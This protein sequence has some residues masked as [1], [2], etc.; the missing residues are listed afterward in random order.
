MPVLYEPELR[1]QME[2]CQKFPAE[3]MLR[4]EEQNVKDA[5]RAVIAAAIIPTR[6]TLRA[7]PHPKI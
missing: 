3:K 7:D 4:E 5:A 2:K 6:A 1:R